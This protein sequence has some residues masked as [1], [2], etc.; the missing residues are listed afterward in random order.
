VVVPR[1][2]RGAVRPVGREQR[3]AGD[4]QTECEDRQ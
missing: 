1:R 4:D 2:G 3:P